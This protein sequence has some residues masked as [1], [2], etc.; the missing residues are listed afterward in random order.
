MTNSILGLAFSDGSTPGLNY[1]SRVTILEVNNLKLPR[2]TPQK[3]FRPRTKLYCPHVYAWSLL[4]PLYGERNENED[5]IEFFDEAW[6]LVKSAE[7]K[8]VIK[9]MRH[10]GRSK[11]TLAL[12]TICA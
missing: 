4:Y 3:D 9:N 12:I 10:I 5:I 11:N 7:G 6:I 2:M 8:A 1:E